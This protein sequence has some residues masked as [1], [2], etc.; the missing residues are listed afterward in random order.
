VAARAR[1]LVVRRP[2]LPGT[3]EGTPTVGW[4]V[5]IRS[6]AVLVGSAH[7]TGADHV[8]LSGQSSAPRHCPSVCDH[9]WRFK[10][11]QAAQP[12][13]HRICLQPSQHAPA[14]GLVQFATD[15]AIHEARQLVFRDC[16]IRI[17]CSSSLIPDAKS[18]WRSRPPRPHQSCIDRPFRNSQPPGNLPVAPSLAVFEHQDLHISPLQ[19]R[20]RLA[21]PV[22]ALAGNE[23][24][25]HVAGITISQVHL[26]FVI[27]PQRPPLAT[28]RA[29]IAGGVDDR[30]AMQPGGNFVRVGQ[31]RPPVRPP[32]A[33]RAEKPPPPP[34]F[35]PFGPESLSA[36]TLRA[37]PERSPNRAGQGK[38]PST[39]LAAALS[40]RRE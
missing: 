37:Q 10:K 11:R 16:F 13:A 14:R 21:G 26:L 38:R 30:Q 15:Q 25:E 36:A 22:V 24:P 23:P 19:P 9:V 40:F 17:H 18:S 31:G 32:P 2:T 7:P 28:E 35:R 12:P 34:A 39:A 6:R 27:P 33:L 4:A 29:A 8:P 5:P 3:P 1:R 20:Q